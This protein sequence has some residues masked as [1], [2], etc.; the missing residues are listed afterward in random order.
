MVGSLLISLFSL[1]L[2]FLK[3]AGSGGVP[4]SNQFYPLL[5]DEVSFLLVVLS[6][7]ICYLS[8]YSRFRHVGGG[9]LRKYVF[10][11]MFILLI[12]V[13]LFCVGGFLR[14]FVIFEFVIIPIVFVIRVWGSQKERLTANYYFFFYTLF[15]RL[16]L[17]LSV[18]FLL[19][20]GDLFFLL[21]KFSCVGNLVSF[22][23][24][25]IV[26]LAFLCKLPLYRVHI[27]LPKAHVEAPVRRSIVLARLLLKI[28][29]YRLIRCFI[30]LVVPLGWGKYAFFC[31]LMVGILVP[32][33]I[34]FRQVDL[35]SFIAY[36][37]VSHM[38]IALAGLV[39]YN[40]YRVLRGLLVF[41]R[42]GVI[43]PIMFY[44]VNL[45]YERVRTRV[46]VRIR[47][48]DSN[49]K[50]FFYYFLL[51]FVANIR[52]P[53]FVSFFREVALYLSVLGFS[54][55]GLLFL[56][57]FLFFSRV[58][59]IYFLVKIFK[60]KEVRKKMMFLED[61]EILIYWVGI[62]VLRLISFLLKV[63]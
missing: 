60:G 9:E 47:R 52:Y 57:L 27:W 24:L 39:M 16:P 11:I 23:S 46:V 22:R 58:V 56:F 62:Y 17:L 53:P 10:L 40:V 12:L 51:V 54:F 38:S 7:L 2:V 20:K 48:F 29:G 6:F 61:R 19:K 55:G 30:I 63:F 49:M 37:S 21:M 42:H 3:L 34:C 45:M 26:I 41:L 15:G 33:F 43:S 13:I 50:F 18:I 35:K 36:S 5:L 8:I 28:G 32:M 14:F 4:F 59:M 44:S 1:S 31:F 25:V